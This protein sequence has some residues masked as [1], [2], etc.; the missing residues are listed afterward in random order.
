MGLQGLEAASGPGNAFEAL[1]WGPWHS[2]LAGGITVPELGHS[3]RA[4]WRSQSLG[5]SPFA[6][7][8]EE[9]G[10]LMQAWSAG[11][12]KGS[13]SA[14]DSGSVGMELQERQNERAFLTRN[15]QH[16]KAV[17]NST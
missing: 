8:A 1:I 3:R 9:R 11:I 4:R 14:L 2:M 15:S 5:F 17:W 13:G 10:Y 12:D 7:L 6:A 16:E